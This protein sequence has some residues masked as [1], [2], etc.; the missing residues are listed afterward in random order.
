MDI[1]I[2]L[3]FLLCVTLA[4]LLQSSCGFGFGI[5]VM[6]F[7]PFLLPSYG[8]SITISGM[9]SVVTSAVA[10]LKC[11]KHVAWKKLLIPMAAFLLTSALATVIAAGAS[12]SLMKRL[13]GGALILLSGYFLFFNQTFHIRATPV[14]GLIAGGVSGMLGGLFGMAGPPIVIYLL[15]GT[16]TKEEYSGST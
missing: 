16:D 13:L 11:R 8:M 5:F 2:V 14:T 6:M 1:W 15:A 7:F 3:P 10:L 9:L 4:A 12:S